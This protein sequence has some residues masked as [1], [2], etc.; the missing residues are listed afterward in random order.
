MFDFKR[1][2]ILA[3]ELRMLQTTNNLSLDVLSMEFDRYIYF[4]SFENYSKTCNVPLNILTMNGKLND[5]YT[6]RVRKNINVILYHE[7]NKGTPRLNWTLAH[8]TGHI[9]LDHDN[10]GE[11]QEVEAHQFAAELLMPTPIITKL[12]RKISLTPEI[13]AKTFFVSEEAAGRKVGSLSRGGVGSSYLVKEILDKYKRPLNDLIE[14]YKN[15]RHQ[16]EQLKMMN[17][18]TNSIQFEELQRKEV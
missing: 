15:Q 18:T 7:E 6:I 11:I 1:A 17:A 5:G 8:E 3:K 12:A 4:D 2:E 10:D 9:Y 16:L 13:I 14:Y